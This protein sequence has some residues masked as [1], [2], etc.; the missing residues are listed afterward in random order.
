MNLLVDERSVESDSDPA[1]TTCGNPP[2]AGGSHDSQTD[3]NSTSFKS[4]LAS[5]YGHLAICDL[6]VADNLQSLGAKLDSMNL[7]VDE[8][9]VESESDPAT[10]TCG[11]PPKAGGSH[12]S[13]SAV[14]STSFKR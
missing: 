8:R 11:N 7:L 12:D 10:T 4:R 6:T 5:G 3:V 1:T 14:N 2:K 13:Q 9:S